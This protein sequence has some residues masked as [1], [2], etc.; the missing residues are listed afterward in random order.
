MANAGFQ[1]SIVDLEAANSQL[2]IIWVWCCRRRVE[3]NTGL[4]C[5]DR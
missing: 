5:L 2:N 4:E 3:T 1:A